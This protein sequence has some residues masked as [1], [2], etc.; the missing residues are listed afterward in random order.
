[1]FK[2][3]KL[4]PARKLA[5]QYQALLQQAMEAQRSGDIKRYSE[6]TE[7]AEKIGVELENLERK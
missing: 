2:M 3:F 7:A 4:D 1:M 5:Q 6:L